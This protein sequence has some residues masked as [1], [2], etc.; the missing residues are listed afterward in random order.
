[1]DLSSQIRG[2]LVTSSADKHVKIW[3]VL[4]NKPALIHSRDMKM[5]RIWHSS[6]RLEHL[7]WLYNTALS[8]CQGVLFCGSCCPDLP[9]VYAFGGQKDGL[10]VWDI[11]DV[12]AGVNLRRLV[13]I[14]VCLCVFV[15]NGDLLYLQS[16][17]LSEVGNVWWQIQYP[18][19]PAVRWTSHNHPL[20]VR[21][22]HRRDAQKTENHINQR[23]IMNEISICQNTE[24]IY[25]LKRYLLIYMCCLWQMFEASFL[26]RNLDDWIFS[27]YFLFLGSV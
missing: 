20:Y 18:E 25:L 21:P 23:F 26:W 16:R 11:S 1:M 24:Q 10:R 7:A 12:A 13:R 14:C 2:C 15:A 9:F 19:R 22:N 8:L 27:P 3:D 4:G 5:V 6:E 17:K